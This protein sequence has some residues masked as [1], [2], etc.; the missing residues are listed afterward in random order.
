[1]RTQQHQPRSGGFVASRF[2]DER[3]LGEPHR[4]GHFTRLGLPLRNREAGIGTR[5]RRAEE[6]DQAF[7]VPGV[8][9]RR[10]IADG[11]GRPLLAFEFHERCSCLGG[12]GRIAGLQSPRVKPHPEGTIRGPMGRDSPERLDHFLAVVHLVVNLDE[13]IEQ[14]Q[15]IG[16]GPGVD[17]VRERL[18]GPQTAGFAGVERGAGQANF[19]PVAG[20]GL[21]FVHYDEPGRSSH[22]IRGDLCQCGPESRIA[23]AAR[24]FLTQEADGLRV[25]VL[26]CRDFGANRKR[27]GRH[28]PELR[29]GVRRLLFEPG[30][31]LGGRPL[32]THSQSFLPHELSMNRTGSIRRLRRHLVLANGIVEATEIHVQRSEP[33][34][35]IH[36]RRIGT[37]DSLERLLLGIGVRDLL[38]ARGQEQVQ[39]RLEPG[40]LQSVGAQHLEHRDGLGPLLIAHRHAGLKVFDL[41]LRCL[42]SFEPLQNLV[43]AGRIA[44]L[45]EQVGERNEQVEAVRRQFEPVFE[46]GDGGGNVA[47]NEFEPRQAAK[48]AQVARIEAGGIA[49]DRVRGRHVAPFLQHLREQ[50]R[51]IGVFR[52]EFEH[53]A[54][55]AHR[56]IQI[57]RL[58]PMRGFVREVRLELR[59]GVVR[60]RILRQGRDHAIEYDAGLHGLAHVLPDEL[61]QPLVAEQF[62][63]CV[64]DRGLVALARLDELVQTRLG[65]PE[66]LPELR[67]EWEFFE[68]CL[69]VRRGVRIAAHLEAGRQH[70]AANRV[71][72][73]VEAK[74][75]LVHEH[76]VDVAAVRRVAEAEEVRELLHRVGI[77][78]LEFQILPKVVDRGVVLVG[79]RAALGL[80]LECVRNAPR[81]QGVCAGQQPGQRE[82]DDE[83]LE[84]ERLVDR[85]H[86]APHPCVWRF[87]ASWNLKIVKRERRKGQVQEG[88]G[89]LR[90][91]GRPG[92]AVVP[93]ANGDNTRGFL[94]DSW[95]LTDAYPVTD[96][97]P[98]QTQGSLAGTTFQVRPK[99]ARD[100]GSVAKPGSDVCDPRMPQTPHAS[101]MLVAM[102]DGSVRTL[103][104]NIA[105]SVFWGAVTPSGGEVINLD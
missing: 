17:G 53:A 34:A 20:S 65:R 13:P 8:A 77:V 42:A 23:G 28:G 48:Q 29:H 102:S 64:L 39:L 45:H 22:R 74:H 32:Q 16:F 46:N 12:D 70:L 21:S 59:A 15:L 91:L 68:Q 94:P 101:G 93:A 25:L 96:A 67:F 38:E 78:R 86:D 95:P 52:V 5:R 85:R 57:R 54:K 44:L 41:R 80:A 56:R 47:A 99:V 31:I 61:G 6:R 30:P 55:V 72:I 62:L 51:S 50:E 58:P 4:L 37:G 7:H 1:M 43:R 92:S 66:L 88:W 90:E 27:L 71:A 76:E 84:Q 103:S 97:L 14:P 35:C 3:P 83:Q 9:A 63:R 104:P 87:R 75:L 36:I 18:D 49:K 19:S 33:D 79:V 89:V 100:S 105:P 24:R 40:Q 60:E 11:D 73:R 69:G 2:Q 26:G 81:L 10:R 98:G 82:H